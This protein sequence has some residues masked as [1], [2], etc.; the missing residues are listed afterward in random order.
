MK[1]A[2]PPARETPASCPADAVA[3]GQRPGCP[4]RHHPRHPVCQLSPATALIRGP[5]RERVAPDPAQLVE[6]AKEWARNYTLARR[7]EEFVGRE[8]I[9]AAHGRELTPGSVSGF[10]RASRC[11]APGRMSLSP[12][13]PDRRLAGGRRRRRLGLTRSARPG[14]RSRIA[15]Q[16]SAVLRRMEPDMPRKTKVL[17]PRRRATDRR[18][19]PGRRV[20]R[21][22]YRGDQRDHAPRPRGTG[23][24]V[25]GKGRGARP[26]LDDLIQVNVDW[27]S[28]L[29]E[30]AA[31][32]CTRSSA[33]RP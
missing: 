9:A 30:L 20:R 6:A 18:R 8:D 28:S 1:P 13:W 10:R 21:Q 14:A 2:A 31:D 19:G 26:V 29:D 22:H 23:Q 3:A 16:L 27:E 33:S 11:P 4:V 25:R 5:A 7:P 17:P 12:G 32:S 24:G 15:A